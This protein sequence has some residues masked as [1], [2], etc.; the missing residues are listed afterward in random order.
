MRESIKYANWTKTREE[1]YK[2]DCYQI[3][4]MTKSKVIIDDTKVF[5]E[6]D[7]QKTYLLTIDNPKAAW[8]QICLKIRD[9][10]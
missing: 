2:K 4:F 9:D 1:L 6:T 10:R 3:L 8:F 5:M 7:N